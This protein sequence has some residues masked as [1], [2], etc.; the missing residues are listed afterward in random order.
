MKTLLFIL[1]L[2]LVGCSDKD[3]S[4]SRD[5]NGIFVFEYTKK[6]GNNPKYRVIKYYEPI[7]SVH[8][9]I[10]R[11]IAYDKYAISMY[12]E[13]PHLFRLRYLDTFDIKH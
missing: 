12:E 1:L 2:I 4:R 6:T 8:A 3:I 10:L 9:K 11:G 7:D 13:Y 5:M